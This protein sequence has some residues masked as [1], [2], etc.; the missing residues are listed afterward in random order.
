[1]L[2][3]LTIHQPKT[4]GG[5]FG[6][7]DSGVDYPYNT[8]YKYQC[9][10]ENRA[11]SM[12]LFGIVSAVAALVTLL[13]PETR[14]RPL[15]QTLD[16]IKQMETRYTYVKLSFPTK[17]IILLVMAILLGTCFHILGP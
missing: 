16:D 7:K 8:H 15:P 17:C 4:V 14:N 1:M 2:T 10:Q 13:L 9:F 3:K 5:T 12:M 11:L 6:A